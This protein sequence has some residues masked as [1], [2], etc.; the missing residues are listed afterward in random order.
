MLMQELELGQGEFQ[1]CVHDKKLQ[2]KVGG[3]RG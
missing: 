1:N 2:E 3:L